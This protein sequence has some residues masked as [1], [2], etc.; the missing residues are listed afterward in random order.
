G[1]SQLRRGGARAAARAGGLG[2][3]GGAALTVA[4]RRSDADPYTVILARNRWA[5][6]RDIS[7]S[8]PPGRLSPRPRL[9]PGATRSTSRRLTRCLRLARKTAGSSRVSR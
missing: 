4:A 5:A 8:L 1:R 9:G 7:I 2:A 6:R 3:G